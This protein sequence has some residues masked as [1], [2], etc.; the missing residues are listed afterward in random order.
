MRLKETRVT[1]QPL[2][3]LCELY[4]VDVLSSSGTVLRAYG[5]TAKDINDV[6]VV[7]QCTR[8]AEIV[9]R[10][11]SDRQDIQREF[12]PIGPRRCL[13]DLCIVHVS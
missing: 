1:R 13:V 3:S 11:Q 10:S 7:G 12:R 4:K 5:N 9:I 2:L 6:T 8:A